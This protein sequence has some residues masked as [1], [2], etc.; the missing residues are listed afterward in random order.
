MIFLNE[1][2]WDF[3]VPPNKSLHRM[4]SHVCKKTQIRVF[5]KSE[6]QVGL[7]SET[8]VGLKSGTQVGLK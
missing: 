5:L 7:K 2:G 8:Q 3:L 6:T 1:N 4:K